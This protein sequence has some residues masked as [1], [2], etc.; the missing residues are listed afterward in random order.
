MKFL[1]NMLFSTGRYPSTMGAGGQQDV[2]FC[3]YI[4]WMWFKRCMWLLG[5]SLGFGG[6]GLYDGYYYDEKGTLYQIE[7]GQLGE[8]GE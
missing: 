4:E 6:V 5:L 1:R 8:L 3:R 2:D 7:N